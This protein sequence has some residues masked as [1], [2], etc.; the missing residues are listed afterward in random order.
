MEKEEL[1]T[2]EKD[3]EKDRRK[4]DGERKEGG[5]KEE[6]KQGRDIETNMR[7][8]DGGEGELSG[9]SCWLKRRVCIYTWERM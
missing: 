3:G 1:K 6:E 9:F 4:K 2:R 8:R 5:K 7:E